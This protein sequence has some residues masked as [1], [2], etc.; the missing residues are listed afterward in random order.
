VARSWSWAIRSTATLG[1]ICCSTLK[2]L[3]VQGRFTERHLED[4]LAQILPTP[5]DKVRG[6]VIF[7][8]YFLIGLFRQS[9]K[10]HRV[11]KCHQK[12]RELGCAPYDCLFQRLLAQPFR[13]I[14]SLGRL[15]GDVDITALN[16][17]I[18]SSTFVLNEMEGNLKSIMSAGIPN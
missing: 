12:T 18:E 10:G 11:E 8:P 1:K 4:Y 5:L 14:D 17:E 6:F 7:S 9:S 3:K 13:S 16:S 2:G 15:K